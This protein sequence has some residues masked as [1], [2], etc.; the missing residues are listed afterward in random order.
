MNDSNPA[1]H[2]TYPNKLGR[3]ILQ[4][5]EEII[6]VN[7][8]NAVLN[9]AH[10]SYRV[11]H[12][13]SNDLDR[14]VPFEEVSRL[15]VALETMYGPRGGRGVAL[16]NGRA[17]FKY[18]LREF[19][20]MMGFTD[21]AFRLLPLESKMRSGAE[22]FAAIF[23]E[24]TD[25]IVRLEENDTNILWHIDRCPV[26]WQRRAEEPVCHLAVGLLQEALYWVSGGKYFQ[27][28]ETNCIAKGDDACTIQV[29]KHPLD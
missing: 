22:I 16:R 12:Y 15:Q 20:P 3:I 25:Q 29:D 6:G 23:N 19:G 7:G 21:T 10:L 1:T 28:Q 11:G 17:C 2:Y 5:L 26:C 9:Q 18:G 27:V 14:G 8:V 4:A 24:F 13:P